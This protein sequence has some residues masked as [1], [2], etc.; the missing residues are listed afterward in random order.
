MKGGEVPW[1]KEAEAVDD[2]ILLIGEQTS[3]LY[4]R[5]VRINCR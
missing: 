4:I 2:K 5:K 1:T 3:T